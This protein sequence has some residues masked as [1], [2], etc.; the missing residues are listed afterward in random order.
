MGGFAAVLQRLEL[1]ENPYPGLRPFE[2]DEA[3]LFFGRDQQI[4]ELVSRLERNRFV[5]VVGVSG[6][7]K[8]SL[9]RAG[10]IPALKLGRLADSPRQWRAVV[11]RPAGAP[12]AQLA[13]RLSD[14][15]LDP[16][17]LRQSSY[18][19]V[20]VAKQ[21]K[22][23]ESLL[24]LV[25]Q[26]EELFRYKERPALRDDQNRLDQRQAAAEAYDFVQLLLAA[27]QQQQQIFLVI[28]M[29]SD[30]LGDCAEFRDLPE[31]LN[32]GQYLIPRLTREQRKQAI[33]CPLGATAISSALVQRMLNDAGD[34][35]GQLPILQHALMRTWDHWHTSDP[36]QS[37]AISLEDYESIGGFENALDLHADELLRGVN[38]DL[39]ATI[40][41]R[42]TARADGY[43]ERREPATLSELWELCAAKS[44]ED[45]AKVTAVIDHFRQREATFLLPRDGKL[46]PDDY[47]DISH[48]SL[49]R[50][51][52]T[53]RDAWLQQEAQS[54][55]TFLDLVER[56][57][58]WKE[59]R[60][61]LLSGLDLRDAVHWNEQRNQTAAWARHYAADED[62]KLVLEFI[63]ASKWRRFRGLC[64]RFVLAVGI[65]LL[66]LEVVYL[67]RGKLFE[68]LLESR[69]LASF[70]QQALESGNGTVAVWLCLEALPKNMSSPDRPYSAEAEAA[71]FNAV[72]HNRELKDLQGHTAPV[73]SVAFSGDGTRI[74][75]ASADRT[76]RVW[77]AA[78]GRNLAILQGH[79]NFVSSAA[80][81]PDGTRIVTASLDNTARVWDA[82]SGR[83]LAILQGHTDFVSAAA[84]SPDGTLIV[85]VSDDETARVWDAASGRNLAVLRGHRGWV[86]SA[87]FSPDDSRIVTASADY[88]ARVW[89]AASGRNLAILQ[90][91]TNSLS[92]AAFSPDGTRIVT[93]SSDNTT[94][95]WDAASGRSLAVLQG[96]SGPVKWA[97]F[98]PDGRR[99]VTASL[100]NTARVWDAASG[101]NLAILQGHANSVRSAVFSPDG[102]RIVTASLDN[103]ARVWDAASGRNLAILQGHTNSL[104]WAAFSPDGTRIVTASFDDTA[105][106]WDATP[107]RYLVVL[108]AHTSGVASV[109]FGPD[110]SRVVTASRDN[111]A[112]VWDATSGNSLA[113]L[114]GHS[115]P[116]VSAVYGPDGSRIVTASYDNTARVW[117]AASGNTVVVLQGHTGPVYSAALSPDGSR[118]VTAST[119]NTA[120]VWDAASGH[121][122]AILQGHTNSVRSAAFSRG[123]TRI[124]TASDDNTAR[125]WDA[126]SGR[127]LAVMR[128]HEDWIRS[129]AF[130]PD[131]SHVVTASDDK[132]ARVWDADSGLCLAVLQGHTNWVS[133]AAFSPSGTRIVTVSVDNTARVWDAASGRFLVVLRGHTAPV[134]SASFSSDGNRIVTASADG[135]ARVWDAATGG[136]VAV[137]QGH[138][139]GVNSAAFNRE[140]TRVVT[141]SADGTAR[142]WP[143]F[144]DTQ[145]LI[146]Y[147]KATVPRQLTAEERRDFFPP[148]AVGI[149]E[150][151]RSFVTS[152]F[153]FVTGLAHRSGIAR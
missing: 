84:F 117:D 22:P 142:I 64:S 79:T 16:E 136:A 60:G 55:K 29:R 143:V 71:L 67:W 33:E 145:S 132:T 82:A 5:A 66:I 38:R 28:T 91:H 47:I 122:L 39:A 131:G 106:V 83:N 46:Q 144:R 35:P 99:I 146:N 138:T 49:I 125:V 97:S 149:W 57:R 121:N 80:F 114:Q 107:G 45:K 135:T 69:Y 101:R 11:T 50:R 153:S 70:S 130:S 139:A 62:L 18:G 140:G 85:T 30:Y 111:T 32:E 4:S 42:L 6:S 137:L 73:I 76:A 2:T 48:E 89:D 54:A 129:A 65:V 63:K 52:K 40:F 120:R 41:K 24:V 31:A 8:S 105:R 134:K 51:W 96:H 19:L 53:L 151:L 108:K 77:D 75:T 141:A 78:S 113:V 59:R 128:G 12:F 100:D 104:S 58:S 23:N 7:G 88:T 20:R 43:R 112:R 147:A 150:S 119:D 13:T 81:S 34:E 21:L 25:D 74:V 102:T 17:P 133:W 103:T 110:D 118:I 152:F 37:R 95:V 10:L 87:V 123:G 61:A 124:V 86:N 27:S 36:Q 92:W 94:R 14:A 68:K 93:A 116:V 148:P 127:S 1:P 126:A 15:G 98:S 3:H 9:V 26:F 109:S 56:A 115:G 72:L 44:E 90:G